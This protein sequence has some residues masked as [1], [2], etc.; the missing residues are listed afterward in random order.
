MVQSPSRKTRPRLPMY[1][2]ITG[3]LFEQDII[4]FTHWQGNLQLPVLFNEASQIL[5][6]SHPAINCLVELGPHKALAGPIRQIAASLGFDETRLTYLPTLIRG[7]DGIDDMLRL[8]GN[9]FGLGYPVD[10]SRVNSMETV[11]GEKP[12]D[13]TYEKGKLLVDLP[14]YQWNYEELLWKESRWGRELRFRKHCRHDI[15]GS[16]EPGGS[17]NSW[18][19]RNHLDL[20]LVPWLRDHKVFSSY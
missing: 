9:I 19:W 20:N 8:A 13:I 5:L 7:Q 1:S 14:S 10:I 11:S 6:N 17:R 4:P 3:G 2:S 18:L 16:L 15:L 12:E